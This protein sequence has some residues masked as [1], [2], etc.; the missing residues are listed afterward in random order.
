MNMMIL[1]FCEFLGLSRPA[2]T[3][4]VNALTS[5]LAEC[6]RLLNRAFGAMDTFW[7]ERGLDADELKS[8]R[9]RNNAYVLISC[10]LLISIVP[11][12]GIA[13]NALGPTGET[14]PAELS[15]AM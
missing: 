2:L 7:I 13:L 8:V 15:M 3:V 10:V 6:R 12:V 4:A 1:L 9:W 11:L 14:L 5:A